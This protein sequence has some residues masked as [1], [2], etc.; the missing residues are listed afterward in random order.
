VR[1]ASEQTIQLALLLGKRRQKYCSADDRSLRAPPR[2]HALA[3][4]LK[5]TRQDSPRATLDG[6]LRPTIDS[7]PS[8]SFSDRKPTVA[9]DASVPLLKIHRRCR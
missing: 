1:E 4:L 9:V 7:A 2:R 8:H 6:D 3:R 5:L